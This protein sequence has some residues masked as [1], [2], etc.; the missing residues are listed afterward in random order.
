VKFC[1]HAKAPGVVEAEQLDRG[2]A[3]RCTPNDASAI[4]EEM[5]DPFVTPWM[6]KRNHPPRLR[7]HR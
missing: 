3:N 2:A 4:K 1:A 6:E 5:L 7:V